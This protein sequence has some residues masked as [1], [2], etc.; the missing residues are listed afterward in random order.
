MM[1]EI[2]SKHYLSNFDIKDIMSSKYLN[3][4]INR[5]NNLINKTVN[6]TNFNNKTL[7]FIYDNYNQIELD[8]SILFSKVM[9]R[10]N[11]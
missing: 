2:I 7:E 4:D 9:D 6:T 8:V 11:L 3:N 1:D 5:I 10:I